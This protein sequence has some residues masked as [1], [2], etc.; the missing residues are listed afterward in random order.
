M[1]IPTVFGPSSLQEPPCPV[2][3]LGVL[4]THH[5]PR[6]ETA[7]LPWGLA[8]GPAACPPCAATLEKGWRSQEPVLGS[9]GPFW[10]GRWQGLWGRC[11]AAGRR[12]RE[13]ELEDQHPMHTR[14]AIAQALAAKSPQTDGEGRYAAPWHPSAGAAPVTQERSPARC[15]SPLPWFFYQ[16]EETQITPAIPSHPATCP[17]LPSTSVQPTAKC[18]PQSPSPPLPPQPGEGNSQPRGLSCAYRG[19]WG[20]GHESCTHR[21]RSIQCQVLL[22]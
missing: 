21:A 20:C 4:Q 19:D 11:S 1:K 16:G 14:F 17:L 13:E 22:G 8:E 10:R 6:W 12:Q 7:A 3:L 5:Q 15:L 18:D 2:E 9:S